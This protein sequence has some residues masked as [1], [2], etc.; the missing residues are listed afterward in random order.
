MPATKQFSFEETDRKNQGTLYYRL[1][2]FFRS[3][4]FPFD[5][6]VVFSAGTA[7]M[8]ESE[9]FTLLYCTDFDEATL[10]DPNYSKA[11]RLTIDLEEIAR[12]S[13]NGIVIT[14]ETTAERAPATQ[15]SAGDMQTVTKSLAYGER[16]EASFCCAGKQRKITFIAGDATQDQIMPQGYN[17]YFSGRR[18]CINQENRDY[19][20]TFTPTGCLE[21][22]VSRLPIGGLL[23]PD[24]DA[25]DRLFFE[26]KPE[27]Y[28]LAQVEGVSEEINSGQLDIELYESL[29]H[30]YREEVIRDGRIRKDVPEENYFSY[31]NP[32]TSAEEKYN[33]IDEFFAAHS[34][35]DREK[36]IETEEGLMVS[37]IG[38]TYA[39]LAELMK[40]MTVQDGITADK[41]GISLHY[42]VL[43]EG[44]NLHYL[45]QVTKP[46]YTEAELEAIKEID[47]K[48]S[49]EA[50]I[51]GTI[52]LYRKV[53]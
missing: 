18:V 22:I 6:K 29:E 3:S 44:G 35:I 19:G 11:S 34:K 17:V 46:A 25:P 33:S 7:P 20:I 38:I 4:N 9:V 53:R 16:L 5:R 32:E 30:K 47:E 52:S 27:E 36:C 39:R 21:K 23:F 28:G 49:A 42:R 43:K 13:D 8:R 12:L 50:T 14:A 2:Q 45:Q 10:V 1:S 41:E 15:T 40:E 51:K 48:V 24:R 37:V 31:I 26:K